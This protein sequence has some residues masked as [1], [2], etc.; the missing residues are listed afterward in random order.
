[1]PMLR[2]PPSSTPVRPFSFS[3]LTLR[4]LEGHLCPLSPLLF[5]FHSCILW[6]A[7]P[8][9][10]KTSTKSSHSGRL[11]RPQ[12]CCHPQPL[13]WVS[14]GHCGADPPGREPQWPRRLSF[15][16]CLHL[17][18]GAWG[19]CSTGREGWRATPCGEDPGEKGLLFLQVCACQKF[20]GIPRMK[21]SCRTWQFTLSQLL[22]VFSLNSQRAAP[23]SQV[24]LARPA[25]RR[26]GDARL[27]VVPQAH[28]GP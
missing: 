1:M 10:L 4:T 24:V 16:I 13:H 27:M 26:G 17:E 14:L 22:N 8:V 5:L 15:P 23:P 18:E 11:D 7:I 6:R 28:T 3:F 12:D 2:D 21:K 9:T 25:P 19:W 20:T